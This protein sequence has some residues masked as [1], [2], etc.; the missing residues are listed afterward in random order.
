MSNSV[1]Y[2]L[3]MSSK[4]AA[5]GSK[6]LRAIYPVKEQNRE[7]THLPTH[8]HTHAHAERKQYN[9]VFGATKGNSSYLW[10]Q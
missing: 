10:S 4:G 2:V 6:I 3:F 1:I 7:C 8:A 9:A 5:P